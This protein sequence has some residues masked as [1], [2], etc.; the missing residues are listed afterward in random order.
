MWARPSDLFTITA[1]LLP[2]SAAVLSL[3]VYLARRHNM[4]SQIVHAESAPIGTSGHSG[5]SQQPAIPAW[6][7][8]DMV[9][10][11]VNLLKMDC[12]GCEYN[13]LMGAEKLFTEHGV[14]ILFME[15]STR[16]LREVTGIQDAGLQVMLRLLKYGMTLW[17]G[18]E[19][20]VPESLATSEE[21]QTYMAQKLMAGDF[22]D[23]LWAVQNSSE[24]PSFLPGSKATQMRHTISQD[25]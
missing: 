12:Q 7:L 25:S 15:V 21:V 3:R 8:D 16:M 14:D 24:L 19:H 4:G 11:H 9:H 13:A 1:V 5:R 17:A 18:P 2:R 10:E 23:N 6:T 22:E 20:S